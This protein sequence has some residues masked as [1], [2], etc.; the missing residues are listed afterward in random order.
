MAGVD[1]PI[2][3]L[4]SD[5]AVYAKLGPPILPLKKATR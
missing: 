4:F 2:A 3:K 1:N 5:P